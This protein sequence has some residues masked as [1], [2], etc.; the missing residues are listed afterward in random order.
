LA[1]RAVETKSGKSPFHYMDGA[2][3]MTYQYTNRIKEELYCGQ[4]PKP[5][6]CQIRGFNPDTYNVPVSALEVR[7]SLIPNAG[8]GVFYKE[9]FSKGLYFQIEESVHGMLIMPHATGIIDL[10]LGYYPNKWSKLEN[11]IDGYGFP[12]D[13]FGDVS[14]I[15]D[16]GITTFANHGCN[17]TYNVGDILE[18]TE[19]T[20]DPEQ[21][22]DS[23]LGSPI[24]TDFYDPFADRNYLTYAT[25]SDK[26]TMDVKAGDEVLDNY[27]V[28]S[29]EEDWTEHIEG[30]KAS[31]L[32]QIAGLVVEYE[33]SK[34][35]KNKRFKS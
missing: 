17:G 15:V 14:N 28:H 33:N 10:M 8:R 13:F 19:L 5:A 30:L 24:E 2:M 11:Y 32:F 25:G 7:K 1:K 20:A 12:A 34:R 16:P 35:T 3:A 18:V 27:V 23:L 26:L 29:V 21:M 6:S 31:C 4:T 22:P 9:S